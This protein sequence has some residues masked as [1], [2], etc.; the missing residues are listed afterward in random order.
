MSEFSYNLMT[1]AIIPEPVTCIKADESFI[2]LSM[3]RVTM[4]VF[5]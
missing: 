3:L 2:G 1:Q 4:G 5:L